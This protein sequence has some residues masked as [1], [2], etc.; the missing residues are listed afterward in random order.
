MKGIAFLIS[1]ILGLLVSLLHPNTKSSYLIIFLSLITIGL[2][3]NIPDERT[4]DE[5]FDSIT[6]RSQFEDYTNISSSDF[7]SVISDYSQMTEDGATDLYSRTLYYIVSRFTAN[8]HICFMIIALIFSIFMLKSLRYLISEPNYTLSGACLLLLFLFT[9]CQIEK[10]N[11]FRFYTAYWIAMYAILKI[12]VDNKT[13]Y[14]L[15]LAVT[16][17]IHGSFFIIILIY[18]LYRLLRN[19]PAIMMIIAVIS[20]ILS[21][22]AVTAMSWVLYH[23]PDSLGGHY[24]AYIDIW[25]MNKINK[26]GTGYK[27]VVRL[28]ELAVRI[29]INIIPLF[30]AYHYNSHIKNTKSRNIFIFLLAVLAFV[31]FT[32]MIPDAGSRFC[33]FIFPLIAY[34]WLV[35]FIKEKKGNWLLLLFTSI[36]LFFFLILPWNIYSIPCLRYYFRLWDYDVVLMSPIFLWF[37]Y[38]FLV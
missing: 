35:C 11:A 4:E 32:F 7:L 38:I 23:L 17:I 19:R 28:M 16:P 20:L 29:T 22:F 13:W 1:P 25:Y 15:L 14:L 24:S 33:M 8:Y 12:I 26:E 2:A 21:P 30:F 27:W 5:N 31:N 34:I 36:Y 9:I 6:Y 37:K 10:I 18:I 3:I